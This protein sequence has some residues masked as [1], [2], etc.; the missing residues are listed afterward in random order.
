M[1]DSFISYNDWIIA[2]VMIGVLVALIGAFLYRQR[3]HD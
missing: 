2:A 3:D 1:V